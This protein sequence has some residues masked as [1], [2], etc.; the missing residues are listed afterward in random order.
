MP[1]MDAARYTVRLNSDDFLEAGTGAEA[2]SDTQVI[3]DWPRVGTSFFA[4]G[5]TLDWKFDDIVTLVRGGTTVVIMAFV[6]TAGL[7]Y[8]RLEYLESLSG[9][10]MLVLDLG[11]GAFFPFFNGDI[12]TPYG[13]SMGDANTCFLESPRED[14]MLY[15]ISNGRPL[16][17]ERGFILFPKR[18]MAA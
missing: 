17:L 11:T 9:A 2:F 13:M 7:A 8:W 6:L 5:V 4:V 10:F 12:Q 15:Y 1:V 16:V 14:V 3:D 18:C